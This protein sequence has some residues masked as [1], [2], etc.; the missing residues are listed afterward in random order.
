MDFQTAGRWSGIGNLPLRPHAF[1]S[2]LLARADRLRSVTGATEPSTTVRSLARGCQKASP[3]A[4]LNKPGLA[5]SHGVGPKGLHRL[6]S[7]P[8][9]CRGLRCQYRSRETAL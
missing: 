7:P 8:I 6:S 3:A 2:A 1:G 5:R 9:R 4:P